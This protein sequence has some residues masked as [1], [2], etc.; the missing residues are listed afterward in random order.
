[1]TASF[2]KCI[3]FLAPASGTKPLI[4]LQNILQNSSITNI[5][6]LMFIVDNVHGNLID[7]LKLNSIKFKSIQTSNETFSAIGSLIGVAQKPDFI[8]SCGWGKKI[9]QNVIKLPTKAAINCHSSFLPDYKGGSVYL[10]QWAN[11]EKYSG[12]SIHFLSDKFDAGNIICQK[13]FEILLED[14]PQDILKKASFITADLLPEALDLLRNDYN[15][16]ENVGGRYFLKTNFMHL[17]A[18]RFINR[19][20]DIIGL[21]ARWL[22]KWK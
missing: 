21:D 15:G 16:F 18:H 5:Y 14:S 3:L 19:F 2:K 12:A 9:P 22:T 8:I 17:R 1:M 7:Y 11:V 10:Y 4:V 6:E 13:K 20:F